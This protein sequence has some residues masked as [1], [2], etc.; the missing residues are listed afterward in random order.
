MLAYGV[1]EWASKEKD[2]PLSRK[3]QPWIRF[4]GTAV[5]LAPGFLGGSLNVGWL[6][7]FVV[8]VLLIHCTATCSCFAKSIDYAGR[9]FER[10]YSHLL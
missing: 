5:L 7:A 4:G 6:V 1:I 9:Q 10:D 8:V 2:E 3:P